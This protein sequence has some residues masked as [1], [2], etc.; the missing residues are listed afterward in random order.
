MHLEGDGINAQY[1]LILKRS[2]FL[3][4]FLQSLHKEV[5]AFYE[6]YLPYF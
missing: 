3:D 6:I 4:F 5:R 1:D 2:F